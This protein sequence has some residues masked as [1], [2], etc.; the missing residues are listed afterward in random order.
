MSFG[1]RLKD[2][3]IEKNVTQQQVGDF[4]GVGRATIAGYETKDKH[5]DFDKLNLL[6]QFFNVTTDYLI[7]VPNSVKTLDDK[8]ITIATHRTDF[9]KKDLDTKEY[10]TTSDGQK[11]NLCDDL[12]TEAREQLESYLNYLMFKYPKED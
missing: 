4:L 1:Q 10:F 9:Y 11:V 3:R 7:G 6:A 12:S 2:L 8:D 5:P